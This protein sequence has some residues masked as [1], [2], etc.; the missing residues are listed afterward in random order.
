MD[1]FTRELL[2][3]KG[4]G[5]TQEFREIFLGR[6][7]AASNPAEALMSR[8][9]RLR[10]NAIHPATRHSKKNNMKIE[11]EFNSHMEQ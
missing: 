5:S 9:V 2:Q 3:L 11:Q 10:M 6:Y 1:T 4:E 7:R 8:K